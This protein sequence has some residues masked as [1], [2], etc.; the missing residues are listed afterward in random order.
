MARGTPNKAAEPNKNG[1]ALTAPLTPD[2]GSPSKGTA[3][4]VTGRKL[5]LCDEARRKGVARPL[6]VRVPEN[7]GQPLAGSDAL[8]RL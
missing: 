7:P 1:S 5:V 6:L 3:F 8:T 4:S 2:N